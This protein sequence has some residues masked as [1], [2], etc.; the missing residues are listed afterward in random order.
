MCVSHW[1]L[2]HPRSVASVAVVPWDTGNRQLAPAMG[3]S[4]PSPLASGLRVRAWV[5]RGL[6][7]PPRVI[8]GASAGLFVWQ[9]SHG[10]QS[11]SQHVPRPT[12]LPHVSL[13]H[14]QPRW[15]LPDQLSC[16]PHASAA[17]RT[18]SC[19]N[20]AGQGASKLGSSWDAW[21]HRRWG[22]RG[23]SFMET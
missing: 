14:S 9:V 3:S 13:P 15:S 8:I 12:C 10:G 19:R 11:T 2:D 5:P 16:L 1:H 20:P 21:G 18:G 4:L 6:H 7:C 17:P 23:G 22:T